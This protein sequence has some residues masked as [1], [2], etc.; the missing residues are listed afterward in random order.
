[1]VSRREVVGAMALTPLL[2]TDA[3]AATPEAI[4]QISDFGN[5]INRR[6]A[7]RGNQAFM[8]QLDKD[9]QKIEVFAMDLRDG[10]VFY[11]KTGETHYFALRPDG[12]AKW[13]SIYGGTSGCS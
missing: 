10:K 12:T 7:L 4:Y 1:M 8:Q 11:R 6:I 3:H 2:S 13:T 9:T 5:K